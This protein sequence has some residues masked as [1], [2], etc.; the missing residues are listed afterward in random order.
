MENNAKMQQVNP[1]KKPPAMREEV[2]GG[3]DARDLIGRFRSKADIYEYLSEHRKSP[4]TLKFFDSGQYYLPPIKK[5]TK[6]FLKEVFAG[7]KHL[8]PRA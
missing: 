3:V 7:R 6:D 2:K 8:I 5:I 1:P 4:S